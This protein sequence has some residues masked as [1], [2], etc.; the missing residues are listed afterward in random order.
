[1]SDKISGKLK[2]VGI[3]Y[4]KNNWGIVECAPVENKSEEPIL[5]DK[6]TFILK[7]N[8][9]QPKIDLEYD[10]AAIKVEDSKYGLQYDIV[11]F[12]VFENPLRGSKETKEKF[13]RAIFTPGIVYEMYK[14]LPDPFKVLYEKNSEELLKVW[15]C[16]VHKCSEWIERF[17]KNISLNNLITELADWDISQTMIEKICGFFKSADVALDII[18][19]RPYELTKVPGIGF[20]KA[21]DIAMSSG[22]FT[23]HCPP[24]VSA[25]VH[26]I[27]DEQGQS[28]NS[29]VSSCYVMDKIIEYFGEDITDLEV[30]EAMNYGSLKEELWY[31]EDKQ[32]IGLKRYYDLEKHM[33]DNVVELLENNKPV[34]I[35]DWKKK[36]KEQELEQ[37]WG[38]TEQQYQAIETL[39]DKNFV[40][41]VGLGG[42]GKTSV[43]GAIIKLM[44][45]SRVALCAL[46]GKAALR[47][48][49]TAELQ[50]QTIHRLLG[51]AEDG[52]VVH[53]K[54]N[55]LPYDLV[56]VDEV[57]M[58]GGVLFD[59]LLDAIS[60]STKVLLL[61]DTGQ[62]E[63]IGSCN[64]ASD[65]IT[66]N[67]VPV[68]ILDKIHRQ[69][70]KSGIITE[71]INIR[72]GIQVIPK[73]YTGAK[74]CGELQDLYF[75]CYSDKTN[76]VTKIMGTFKQELDKYNGDIN[77]VQILMAN[78]TKSVASTSNINRLVQNMVN[79]SKNEDEECGARS[80]N[81]GYYLTYRVGDK[82]INCKNNYKA[83][84]YDPEN[85]LE[86][87]TC[88]FNGNIGI[89]KEINKLENY[90]LIDFE[91]IGLLKFTFS[92]MANL[93]LAYA[94]T[95][96]KYQGS[97]VED[98]IFGLDFT[99]Y[100]M[101]SRQLVYTAMT[102][103]TKECHIIAQTGALRYAI[104]VDKI[105][106]KATHLARLINEAY[107]PK[108][109]EEFT[110]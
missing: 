22:N 70:A 29:Y 16:G 76:T 35:K 4:Y 24:R 97:Q 6:G 19:N 69:A 14:A 41:V 49:E 65:L 109:D 52:G 88:V 9:I 39:M 33:A 26:Y 50:S 105:S 44:K 8:M 2:V 51:V 1:M 10:Y 94:V 59:R 7:G 30:A 21:D 42:T 27:L 74:I 64:V 67:R 18:K 36:I 38:F 78:K 81:T 98:V 56:V 82:V 73:D 37:G 60:P 53:N 90:V 108:K 89:I 31:T 34:E 100:T 66:S 85:D 47:L 55:P 110:F 28:G 62:L 95:V 79:P 77:K 57:S 93:D 107:E 63:A 91:R 68:V 104:G 92:Q 32:F 72:K 45:N 71:S 46:S 17:H 48:E 5:S 86:E 25:Y 61:G 54:D 106:T 13:L 23:E 3:R 40:I 43:A 103:A 12:G 20:A 96:H 101:L 80:M 84:L 15:G 58:I 11:R 75:D 102:R 99:A 87:K 83:T